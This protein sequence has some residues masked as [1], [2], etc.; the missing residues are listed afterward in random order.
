MI[1]IGVGIT[2]ELAGFFDI[3]FPLSITFNYYYNPNSKNSG[4]QLEFE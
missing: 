2:F 1:A 4:F 3:K